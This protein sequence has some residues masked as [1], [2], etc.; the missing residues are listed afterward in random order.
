MKV[1]PA[2][3]MFEKR[4]ATA[5]LMR[6]EFVAFVQILDFVK[7]HCEIPREV[8]VPRLEVAWNGF[9][10]VSLFDQCDAE[11]PHLCISIELRGKISHVH[12]AEEAM[13]FIAEHAGKR[14]SER[15]S[16]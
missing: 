3:E 11:L 13:R 1:P 9:F 16:Q 12:S 6:D 8:Y 7:E 15:R 10:R 4:T 5:R 2:A 14:R